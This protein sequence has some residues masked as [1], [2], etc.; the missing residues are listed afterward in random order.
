MHTVITKLKAMINLHDGEVAIKNTEGETLL[1]EGTRQITPSVIINEK[2]NNIK[3]SFN[4]AN[5]E[6]LYG[7]G[8]HQEGIFNW[9]GHYAELFQYNM[10]AIVPFLLS[11]KGYGI[12][13]DNYSY[14]KFND[15]PSGSYLWSEV[16]DAINYFFIYGPEP[17]SVIRNYREL[18]GTAPLFPKW[19]YGYIQSKERYKTQQ[20]IINVVKEY[21]D[22]KIPLDA[23][24]LDWQYWDDG[25]WG[26]KSFNKER[27]PEPQL[28]ME[29]LHSTYNAHLMI[30]IW[31]KMSIRS[32]NY[33]EMIKHKGFLYPDENSPFYDAFNPEART[34]YWKQAN[35]GLFSKGIDAW[36]CDA[37]EPEL[38]G[39]DFN[40]DVYKIKMKPKIGSG[41]RYMNAYSLMHS[42]GIYENQRLTTDE[43]RVVN[44][45][46]SAF[47]GQQKYA[48][49][50]WSGDIVANWNV[51]KN[52]ITAGL[53]F[54]MSGLPYWTTD[55]GGF[56]V[57]SA[58]V[59]EL[60]KG[61]WFRNGDFDGGTADDNYKELY[62]RW[63]QF[64]AFCPVFRSHG[65]D[66]S[67][68]IWRLGEP[69]T[70]AFDALLKLDNLRYRLMPY[71]YSM[72]WKVTSEGYTLMRG[73]VMDFRND[74]HV[75]EIDDQFMFGQ[76][77]LVNPVTKPKEKFRKVYLP[78]GS[79][80]YNFWTG[81]RYSGGQTWTVPTPI[82]EMP[83]FIKEGSIIL[84]GPFVQYASESNDPIELRI[85]SGADGNFTLYED[86]NDNYNY[87]KGYF[88]I[89]DF[90]WNDAQRTLTIEE[91]KGNFP[92]M[93][94][95]RNFYI[96]FVSENIGT[97][98]NIVQKPMKIV[99][100]DGRKEIIEL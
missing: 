87:E 45:T 100:Y 97:G 61:A 58:E 18:T 33:S 64:G 7:L 48:T 99:Q 27:F 20:E 51:F 62:V 83:I 60:G 88:S 66:I 81:K 67:R 4:W 17:D 84:L 35:K 70:L 9:R 11:T 74:H 68:E 24:V 54:C 46:R 21:R 10:R 31:P 96:T 49:I 77:I 78:M 39:W 15:T 47:A 55:I 25:K 50:T 57:Q 36:W 65:T 34:L 1:R 29:T 37:T 98:V 26:Q 42:K 41:A 94:E 23:I 95:E 91:R 44:L 14:T 86:E 38:D 52:Q 92:G 3:Q 2:V 28:M 80:W 82:D 13:W 93:L 40:C 22:R 75:F 53:N 30:S 16:G 43:K 69:G 71:I 72:A 6:A 90:N 63:F 56:F 76:S 19:T 8:Q 32:S 5:D 85:Y 79:G 59:G 89:I 73:L 12:L